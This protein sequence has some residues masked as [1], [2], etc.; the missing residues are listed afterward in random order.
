MG[1]LTGPQRRSLV[2]ALVSAFPRLDDLDA[3]LSLRLDTSLDKLTPPAALPYRAMRVVEWAEARGDRLTDLV[4]GALNQ[5]PE[6][7][8]LQAVAASMGLDEGAGDFERVVLEKVPITD[9]EGWRRKMMACERTVCRV[10]IDGVG[11]GTGFLVSPNVVITNYHV[12]ESEMKEPDTPPNVKFRF[13]YKMASDGRTVQ[14]GNEYNLMQGNSWLVAS[15][16]RLELD[17]ALLRVAGEP[18]GD[19]VASQRGAPVRGFLKPED[20]D[21]KVGD[22]L[23]IIQH[24]KAGPLK[25]SPGSVVDPNIAPNK[26]AYSVNTDEGSSGSPCFTSNWTP[27]ALHHWGGKLHNRGVAFSAILGHLR[28]QGVDEVG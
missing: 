18:A 8:N 20:Y 17:Y 21:F 27:V 25:F 24:P 14:E 3:M 26:V 11:I 10:E 16:P 19:E 23:F 22:P 4:I 1:Q 7:P 13:D 6:N 5:N 28:M 2:D 12:I 9:V 15:S